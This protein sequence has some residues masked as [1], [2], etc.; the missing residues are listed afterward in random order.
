MRLVFLA[1]W[2][3]MNNFIVDGLLLLVSINFGCPSLA[4]GRGSDIRFLSQLLIAYGMLLK[5]YCP[6]IIRSLPRNSIP[7]PMRVFYLPGPAENS[8]Y[9]FFITSVLALSSAMALVVNII[10]PVEFPVNPPRNTVS[11]SSWVTMP[12]SL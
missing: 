6:L 4:K 9:T 11:K 2:V 8:L 5:A 3:G 1:H 7:N 10:T 12:G